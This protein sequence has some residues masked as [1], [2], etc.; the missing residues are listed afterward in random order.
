M[1]WINVIHSFNIT[2]PARTANS[3]PFA[4]AAPD[5]FHHHQH[6]TQHDS[7]ALFA[8]LSTSDETTPG[9]PN[10]ID[11]NIFVSAVETINEAAGI[12]NSAAHEQDGSTAGIRYAIGRL[13]VTL[14]IPPGIDLVETPNL[15]VIN[16]VDQSAV[17]AGIQLL[18]TIV[19]VS[20]TADEEYTD[21]KGWGMDDMFAIIKGAIDQAR[22]ND[23]TEIR[24]EL[25]RLVKGYYK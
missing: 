7:T 15:V 5:T 9:K 20:A 25:N 1:S 22:E 11:Q 4:T 21:T 8:S 13:E 16:G 17:D 24:L 23:S 18:D 3:A 6:N 14:N 19:G 12:D 2:G 10:L